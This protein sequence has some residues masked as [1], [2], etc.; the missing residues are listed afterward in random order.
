MP[1]VPAI[2]RDFMQSIMDSILAV[3]NTHNDYALIMDTEFYYQDDRVMGN[4]LILPET[5]S[6]RSL[7]D[8][9]QDE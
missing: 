4:L 3:Y 8:H 7:V 2:R 1:D 9:L 6:L 5:E